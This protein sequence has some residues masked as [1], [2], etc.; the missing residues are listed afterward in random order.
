LRRSEKELRDLVETIPTLVWSSLPDGSNAS[1]NRRWVDYSGMSAEQ[2]AGSGWQATI[3]PDDFDAYLNKWRASLASGQP[4]ETEVRH[5]S[6]NGAYRW[7]LARAVP[8]RDEHGHTLKWY[9]ILTD[10]EDRKRAEEARQEIEEQWKAAFESNPTMYFIV[11]VP[12]EIVSVNAF[13]AEQ[14]GYTVSELVGQSVSNIFYEP[15]RRPVRR[16]AAACFEQPGRTM[17]WEARKIRKDGAM[18]WVRET[19]KAVLL[20][21]RLVLLVVCEDIT[22][23]KRAEEAARRSEK[24]L[25]DV[26]EAVPGMPFS[27]RADG[28]AEF[29]N[30][31][32]LEYSGLSAEENAG[33]GW[34]SA[35]H[36]DD[37]EQ[38]V[39]KWRASLASGQPFEN[40]VRNR[41]ANGEYRW[42]LVRAVPLRDEHGSILKWY[43]LVTDIEDRKRAEEQLRRSEAYLAE[44]QRLTH[45]GSWGWNTVTTEGLYFSEEMFRIF[46]LDP[47]QGVPPPEKFWERVHPEDRDA[48]Y[49][50][51]L[52]AAGEKTEY[53]HDHRIVLPDGTVKHV[54]AIGHPVFNGAGDVV[55][56]FGT[57]VDV[58]ERK[59]AEAERER[60]HQLEADLA[61]MDRVSMMGELA[62]SLAHEIKQPITAAATNSKTCLRWLQREPPDIGHARE[63]VS[64]IVKDVIRAA[65]IIDRN[66]S[67]YRRDTPKREMANLN[68]LIREM[69]VLLHDA[70]N[71]HS[72]AIRAELDGSIPTI[73]VDRVQMQQVLMNLMLNGIE[74][75]QDKSGELTITSKR[76]EDGQILV[77]V[78]DL[79]I[80]LPVEGVDRIFDA[81][82]TTKA[83]GIG[84]GLSISRRII[85]SH[86]GC[87]WACDN[88]GLGAIFHFT[89]PTDQA[90]SSNFAG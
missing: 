52:K 29:S 58:T 32:W 14:L 68:E 20:K 61:H 79:G 46:A 71:R 11:D 17:R 56:F 59:H 15:D 67:L 88:A 27:A 50:L 36:P 9:G 37:L 65:E 75:M 39:D 83:K 64:R 85:E 12:G 49:E 1:I 73:A 25:R 84:M 28:S 23:Q 13:G 38:H 62:A 7:F 87:L 48:M 78:S 90:P 69:I 40:E 24:E 31:R 74:A 30:R 45:T 6:A 70:K 26:I 89:L 60:L 43:G 66:R 57:T 44:A 47:Q 16:H 3:H 55:E 82:F 86:G 4:F 22:E 8:L 76:T 42:F 19:A 35:V 2:T 41:S 51:M 54:H 18:L 10:I 63:A 72:I 34:Q 21:K 77:S 81:F 53:E 33:S 5:R 80:G